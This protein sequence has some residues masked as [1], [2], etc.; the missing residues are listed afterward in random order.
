M[1]VHI[2]QI[3]RHH[4]R[5]IVGRID[6]G[7]QLAGSE[8]LLLDEGT[9]RREHRDVHVA[10]QQVLED[11]RGDKPQFVGGIRLLLPRRDHAVDAGVA[12]LQSRDHTVI[13]AL[14]F[15]NVV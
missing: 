13:D 3:D 1:V 15:G 6:K 4:V 9:R 14:L 10:G 7:C 8:D 2:C 5:A 12:Q 11:P